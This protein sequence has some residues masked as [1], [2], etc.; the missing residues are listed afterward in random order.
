MEVLF[1]IVFFLGIAAFIACL[2]AWSLYF[3]PKWE[4]ERWART[5]AS[6]GLT[7]EPR[8]RAH[9]IGFFGS[10]PTI[11]Q[12]MIGER[13]G[14]P[15]RVGIRIVV[16]GCAGSAGTRLRRRWRRP[17]TARASAVGWSV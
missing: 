17:E 8:T 4:G 15:V 7:L 9:D 3:R 5:A 16:T 13:G 14:V 12:Q 1:P 11:K 10:G 2:F 6:L